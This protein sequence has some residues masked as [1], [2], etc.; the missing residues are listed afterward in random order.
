M[1]RF[2]L[3]ELQA[4]AILQMQ[5]RRLAALEHQKI[6][7]EKE[8]L[9]VE[10]ARLAEI[11]ANEL[12]IRIEIRK[13]LEYIGEKY[14]NARRTEISHELTAIEKEDLIERRNVLVS[15]TSLNYIKRMDLDTYRQQRRG[16]KGIIGMSTKE[17]DFVESAFVANT[18]D[19]LLCFT[20]NGRV[21]WLKVY[22]IPE[23]S[24]TGR[25]KA[26]VNLLNLNNERVTTVLP[27]K[28]F[29]ADRYL[30]FAT[31]RGM[32]IK[33]PLVEF[34]RPRSTG[35][36]GITLKEHDEL[37]DVKI[38]NGN[39]EILLTTRK[40]QSLR[41]HEESISLRHRNAMGV[42]GIRM[43][44]SDELRAVALLEE[45]MMLLTVTESGYGKRTDF[46]E[47][48]GHGRGTMGVRNILTEHRGG[49]VAAKAV[50]KGDEI[51]MMSASG[52]VIR[53]TVSEI[54]IQKRSTRGV[55]IMKM[56][57]GDRVVGVAVLQEGIE[58][59][60]AE[61]VPAEV[62]GE[63]IEGAPLDDH[64]ED[65]G[66]EYPEET[67]EGYPEEPEEEPGE[68]SEEDLE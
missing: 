1:T 49:V 26:I 4:N 57:E 18:H 51:I 42:I 32:V 5:L 66:E 50:G 33:V 39:R 40:G 14:G 21:Y 47:F 52:I 19:Y 20:S 17:E 23:S 15:L 55:R 68:E 38:T 22:E 12:N 10:I 44:P 24:R 54:S 29:K 11:L 56:D 6:V 27:V 28:A 37:V 36:N 3:D 48:R 41:F 60:L 46:D 43:R 25:G 34:S 53:T 31:K 8:G 63:G 9:L 35:I 16:G 64:E 30:L 2:G 45:N 13:E 65:F 58:E 67:G 7:D 62:S 59:A 61:E